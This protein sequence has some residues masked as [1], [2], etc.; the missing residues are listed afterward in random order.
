MPDSTKDVNALVVETADKVHEVKSEPVAEAKLRH[1][2]AQ[3]E[4]ATP[5]EKRQAAVEMADANAARPDG[6]FAQLHAT[7]EP[8][9]HVADEKRVSELKEEQAK[10]VENLQGS[11]PAGSEAAVRQEEES[12]K[13][14][15]SAA[16]A[17]D[18]RTSGQ[19]KTSAGKSSAAQSK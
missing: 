12:A 8:R 16:Q 3:S 19:D 10:A 17:E 9:V 18:A 7:D 5:Q 2:F 15:R 4:Y 11:A 14:R 13:A 6:S 1:E